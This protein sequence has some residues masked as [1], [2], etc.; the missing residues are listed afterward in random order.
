MR[1]SSNVDIVKFN[2]G[3]QAGKGTIRAELEEGRGAG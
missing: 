3:M 1:T 2:R